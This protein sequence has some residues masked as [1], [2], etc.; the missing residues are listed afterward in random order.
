[1]CKLTNEQYKKAS[2]KGSVH[3][4]AGVEYRVIRRNRHYKWYLKHK[5]TQ[6]WKHIPTK[7]VPKAKFVSGT[8]TDVTRASKKIKITFEKPGTKKRKWYRYSGT[9]K[10]LIT[11]LSTVPAVFKR[12]LQPGLKKKKT[13]TAG[14]APPS[15][16]VVYEVKYRPTRARSGGAST[17]KIY[18]YTNKQI[19]VG[20]YAN[21]SFFT[22]GKP[23][24]GTRKTSVSVPPWTVGRIDVP[25][26]TIK[27]RFM[28]ITTEPLKKST[29]NTPQGITTKPG[30]YAV[31][32]IS[33][34]FNRDIIVYPV[35]FQGIKQAYNSLI[36]DRFEYETAKLLS[37]TRTDLNIANGGEKPRDL[38][39]SGADDN[40]NNYTYTP[41]STYSTTSSSTDTTPQPQPDF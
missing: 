17:I 14:R 33:P 31:E 23:H 25:D 2:F 28:V 3:T 12:L 30:I 9:K 41:T 19:N 10:R 27:G 1:M 4:S 39:S 26:Y 6:E 16:A 13:R 36:V 21:D 20:I 18:N 29:L 8:F 22:F 37:Q 35:N 7:K 11:D 15:P 34:L 38:S 32:E 5:D 40:D 24:I